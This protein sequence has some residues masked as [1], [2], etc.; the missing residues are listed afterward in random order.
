VDGKPIVSRQALEAAFRERAPDSP[1]R[2]TV[3]RD[4]DILEVVAVAMETPSLPRPGEP[5]RLANRFLVDMSSLRAR[6]VDPATRG[7]AAAAVGIAYLMVDEMALALERGF[8]LAELPEGPGV[9]AG[10]VAYLKGI[11]EVSAVDGNMERA[12]AFFAEAARSTDATL[13]RDDGPRVAP[14]A[15]ARLVGGP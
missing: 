6:A 3:N 12:R 14:L 15:A 4:G 1:V 8:E 7:L 11:C 10:T 2:V 5:S 9:S 13:W